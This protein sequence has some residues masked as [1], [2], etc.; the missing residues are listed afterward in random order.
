MKGPDYDKREKSKKAVK[1][2]GKAEKVVSLNDT[3]STTSISGGVNSNLPGRSVASVMKKINKDEY[4]GRGFVKVYPELLKMEG[5]DA[6]SVLFYGVI[7][8]YAQLYKSNLIS[9][10]KAQYE[11]WERTRREQEEKLKKLQEW[12]RHRKEMGKYSSSRGKREDKK[13][14]KIVDQILSEMDDP[15]DIDEL[16]RRLLEYYGVSREVYDEVNSVGESCEV[17]STG[18]KSCESNSADEK[19]C[20]LN[21]MKKSCE[22]SSS[23]KSCEL[24][25]ATKSCESNSATKAPTLPDQILLNPEDLTP[26]VPITKDYPI[27]MIP[28][29]LNYTQLK[30]DIP[31]VHNASIKRHLD[32]LEESGLIE[33][34]TGDSKN[35]VKLCRILVDMECL[36]EWEILSAWASNEERKKKVVSGNATAEDKQLVYFSDD[37]NTDLQNA[38]R[39]ARMAQIG[40]EG[41]ERDN[42]T[43]KEKELRGT[44]TR[45]LRAK[46][47]SEGIRLREEVYQRELDRVGW[48][49]NGESGGE[50]ENGMDEASKEKVVSPVKCAASSVVKSCE[51]EPVVSG[52]VLTGKAEKIA[53]V[54]GEENSVKGDKKLTD[55]D[56]FEW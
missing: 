3:T 22:S 56:D 24:N 8:N 52:E 53:D 28:V 5:L 46:A 2:E 19:S 41:V 15:G 54:K 38:L 21:P 12:I 45:L 11:R 37:V 32:K 31:G 30:D 39:R 6:F 47:E 7:R 29:T 50:E 34:F 40:L 14:G 18:E 4:N 20:E 17:G 9:Q 35:S 13:R 51:L 42:L 33:V 48:V 25:P 10:N 49:E 43:L 16:E 26:F 55:F 1:K 36:S 23:E 44:F 27:T